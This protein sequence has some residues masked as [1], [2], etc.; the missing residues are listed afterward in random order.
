MF[1]HSIAIASEGKKSPVVERAS[2]VML[3]KDTG[4]KSDGFYNERGN[5]R[6]EK[7]TFN[8]FYI[9]SAHFQ[10]VFIMLEKRKAYAINSACVLLSPTYVRKLEKLS[11]KISAGH[12]APLYVFTH[13]EVS[14]T[15]ICDQKLIFTAAKGIHLPTG[16]QIILK[17]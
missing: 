2:C 7:N 5:G 14:V 11:C 15:L 3:F 4:Q 12:L 6:D 10:L 17:L 8:V 13:R 9:L 16:V 1:F